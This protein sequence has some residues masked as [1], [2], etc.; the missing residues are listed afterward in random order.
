MAPGAYQIHAFA[1]NNV[2]GT[3]PVIK[4]DAEKALNEAKAVI[5][6][7]FSTQ[8]NHQAPLEPE[9][10]VAY[11]EGKDEN[12]QLVVA[13]RSIVIHTHLAQIQE[14]VGYTNMRYRKHSPAGILVSNGGYY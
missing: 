7:E 3:Q 8:T 14:A 12:P 4:G 13:G 1:P 9:V 5:E 10:S 11:F 6:A 2:A